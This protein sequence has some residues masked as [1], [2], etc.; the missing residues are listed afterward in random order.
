MTSTISR[1]MMRFVRWFGRAML[2]LL[3]PAEDEA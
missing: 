2:A 1:E 3:F